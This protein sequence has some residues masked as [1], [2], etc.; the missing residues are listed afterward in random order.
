MGAIDQAIAN[1]AL[2]VSERFAVGG[3]EP[4]DLLRGPFERL[5]EVL[6]KEAGIADVVP[7]GEHRLAEERIRPDYAVY[8]GGAIVGFIELKA[9]GKGVDT[10]NYKSH[11]RKQWERLALL[12]NVLYG[13]GQSFALYR[14]GE[15][16]GKVVSFSEDVTTAGAALTVKGDQL[17]AL[18]ENF[19]TWQPTAPRNARQL[20]RMSARLCR[21]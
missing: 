16:V 7:S 19:L 6:A 3:G 12:P 21:V 18:F 5:L 11:D 4:E 14:E 2:A 15:R 9:P 20:A 10:A 1:F 13:D 17:L 8:V